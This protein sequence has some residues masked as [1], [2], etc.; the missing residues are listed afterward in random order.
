[1]RGGGVQRGARRRAPPLAASRGD[2]RWGRTPCLSGSVKE[3]AAGGDRG[4]W[5][6]GRWRGRAIGDEK[7]KGGCGFALGARQQSNAGSH[8]PSPFPPLREPGGGTQGGE[9]AARR[10]TTTAAAL[11]HQPRP[12]SAARWPTVL[13]RG[14]DRDRR[15]VSSGV[16]IAAPRPPSPE[17]GNRRWKQTST[18]GKKKEKKGPLRS[19]RAARGQFFELCTRPPHHPPRPTTTPPE[20]HYI[21]RPRHAP[22]ASH[23]GGSPHPHPTSRTIRLMA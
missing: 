14:V 9:G 5:V 21:A 6:G 2:H 20:P 11:S 18:E 22:T 17:T 16:L 8:C 19:H 1:M 3:G 13:G 10:W 7:G 12:E 15:H 23:R 4:G